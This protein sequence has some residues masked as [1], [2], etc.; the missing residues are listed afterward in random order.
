M[1]FWWML[2]GGLFIWCVVIGL[3]LYAIK[4]APKPHDPRRARSWIIGGGVVIPTLILTALLIYGL[5]M[6]PGLVRPAPEGSLQI[7][8]TGHQWWWRVRYPHSETKSV[9]LANEIR[10]PVGEAVQFE[11]QSADVIH[12]FWIPALGGK[13]DM[14]PG[15]MTKL[16]L[17]PTKTGTYRGVCA[18]Y[19]GS[20]HAFMAFDVVVTERNEFDAWLEQQSQ[21]SV[22]PQNNAA[23]RG[24]EAFLS[25]GCG[26]CHTVRGT[27]A[28]GV[29]GPDLTHVGSRK[30]LAAGTID[31]SVDEFHEW[32][33]HNSTTK[34]DVNMPDFD[35][36]A[37]D[38]LEALSAYLEGLR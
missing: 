20:S 10:L 32:I 19:C 27:E 1:L 2:A 14:I 5:S 29:I 18:E 15:R 37:D 30:S 17:E 4:I 21:D 24:R 11:L 34:P 3:A 26:A 38:E 8:V 12:A 28:D 25:W 7:Q 13:V 6:L 31:N 22:E 23:I 35:M 36:L 16:T 33:A 9:E